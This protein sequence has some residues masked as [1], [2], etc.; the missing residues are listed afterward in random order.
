MRAFTTHYVVFWKKDNQEIDNNNPKYEMSVNKNDDSATLCI[1]NIKNEDGGIYTIEVQS[2]LGD[3]HSSQT[4]L[5]IEGRVEQLFH[6]N[7]K[8]LVKWVFLIEVLKAGLF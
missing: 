6:K 4:L 5:V 2:E 3:S 8:Y 7:N 1:K